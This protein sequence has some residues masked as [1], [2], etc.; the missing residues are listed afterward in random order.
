MP[1]IIQKLSK[2]Y[3]N[4]WALRDVEL[5]ILD[6]EVFGIY[7]GTASGKTTLLKLIA[8]SD[9]S[10][11]GSISLSGELAS[12]GTYLFEREQS[13]GLTSIFKRERST[14]STGESTIEEFHLSANRSE[15]VLLFDD[16]FI[17]IDAIRREVLLTE[18]KRM[19][20]QRGLPSSTRRRFAWDPAG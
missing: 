16:P 17:G 8:G 20:K 12:S 15:G 4:V 2:R 11:G 5:E 3:D 10:N 14:N 13:G 7:G 9:K 6:G 19:S 1:L 18:I